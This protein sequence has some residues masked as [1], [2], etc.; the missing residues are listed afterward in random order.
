MAT[1]ETGLGR[2]VSAEPFFRE[3]RR[4]ITLQELKTP[5]GR[6]ELAVAAPVRDNN[7]GVTLGVLVNFMEFSE[8]NN[9]LSGALSKD[10][11]AVSWQK[12]RLKTMEIYL[13]NKDMLMV[14]ESVSVNGNNNKMLSQ[15]VDTGVVKAC[16]ERQEEISDFYTGYRGTSVAGA[17][18]CLPLMRWTLLVEVAEE[19]VFA[20]LGSMKQSA[21]A[22]AVIVLGIAGVLFLA[23]Y[24]VVVARLLALGEAAGRVAR[25]EYDEVVPIVSADEIG[26]LAESFNRM[27]SEV[28]RREVIISQSEER[29][30]AIIDN[31]TTVIYLK[32]L[33]GRYKLMR[34]SQPSRHQACA[35]TICRS[36]RR[37]SRTSSRRRS[38]RATASITI[39]P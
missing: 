25:G 23:F 14:S 17:S 6:P 3:G 7:T 12:G 28:K 36:F 5:S 37:A 26:A 35:P 16:I 30:R 38:R 39:F 34:Y 27:A 20:P 11:G 19:E 24:K 33:D 2:D 29:L 1:N 21:V 13:V 10:L 22:A 8:L 18:M 15:R 9:V 31:S 4:V 32:G